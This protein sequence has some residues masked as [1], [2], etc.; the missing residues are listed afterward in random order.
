MAGC[1]NI[2]IPL[3]FRSHRRTYRWNSVS[4]LSSV[5]FIPTGCKDLQNTH[6]HTPQR[7]T[8]QTP[9]AHGILHACQR[10]AESGELSEYSRRIKVQ[11]GTAGT[12]KRS[13]RQ[14][15]QGG[16]Y[17]ALGKKKKKTVERE[18]DERERHNHAAPAA[19]KSR[20]WPATAKRRATNTSRNQPLMT[21]RPMPLALFRVQSL[22][23][24]DMGEAWHQNKKSRA[25][26]LL[27]S[28]CMA[29][30][31]KRVRALFLSIHTAVFLF[32]GAANGLL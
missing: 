28:Y 21:Q 8:R 9:T 5:A 1:G 31:R 22:L 4:V 23:M 29:T 13:G 17:R 16:T 26:S 30:P 19:G 14:R 18:R 12:F 11:L 27:S 6:T 10:T 32:L 15:V 7:F 25:L 20:R 2:F 3:P 24:S